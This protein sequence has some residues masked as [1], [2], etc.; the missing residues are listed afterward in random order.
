MNPI[1]IYN[2][3]CEH[4]VEQDIAKK[5]LSVSIY[6]H[7]K[8]IN[9]VD[10]TDDVVIKKS[11]ILLLGKTGTG[12]TL[13]AETLANILD[14][15]F[16][17][18][19]AVEFS[20]SG[21]V[22]SDVDDIIRGLIHSA[23]GDIELAQYGIVYID[24]VDKIASLGSNFSTGADVGHE[25][26]QQALL[27]M[28]EG[29]DI[30]VQIVGGRKNPSNQT[31]HFNTNKVLFIAGGAFVGI[32]DIITK[33]IN[34]KSNGNIIGFGDTGGNSSSD[35]N[36]EIY[37]EVIS[38]DIIEYGLIPE[39][40]GRFPVVAPLHE[41]SDSSML[42]ILTEPKNS[43][44]KQYQKL[45]KLDNVK[46]SFTKKGL[47]AIVKKTKNENLGARGLRKI[48][49]DVMLDI[50]FNYPSSNIKSIKITEN[51][52][53]NGFDLKIFKKSA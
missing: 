7:Y 17:I 20:E 49:E 13:L 14:I 44:I 3:L 30:N 5:K 32:E 33:R 42:K 45:F 43:L 31:L 36:N 2:E 18:A 29:T 1:E 25:G 37:N 24:E 50:M 6:N 47:E 15:P 34:G 11:N 40:V 53:N 8:R 26:V 10:Q 39:F 4:V 35:E 46:L 48:L 41:L 51:V 21:Y 23:Q 38:D 16:T 27:K 12:K 52:V 22:G 9:H 28:V 19:N